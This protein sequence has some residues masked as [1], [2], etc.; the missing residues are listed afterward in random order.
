MNW[1]TFAACRLG[2]DDYLVKPFSGLALI[3]GRRASSAAQRGH[4]QSALPPDFVA[5]DLTINFQSRA[6]ASALDCQS[7]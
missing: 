2:A 4:H 5:G 7:N 3:A 6:V 1:T